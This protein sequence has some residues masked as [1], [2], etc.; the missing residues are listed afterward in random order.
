MKIEIARVF[1][2][3]LKPA[4]Y[5][6]VHGGRGS[7]KSHFFAEQVV[8]KTFTEP[9]NVV[10]L[11]EVQHT[12]DESVKKLIED[13]IL[14]FGWGDYYDIQHNRIITPGGGHIIFRGMQDANA[15]NIKSLEGFDI[16][17]F[18]EAQAMSQRSLELLRPTIRA[19]GSE[20]WFSW[21][22]EN[23]DDP[24]D[25]FLRADE[26]PEGA[27]V[28][29]ANW[30]DNPWFPSE[31]EKERQF[32]F[33]HFP[34]RYRHIWEGAYGA[35]GEP[36]FEVDWLLK[37]GQPLDRMLRPDSIFLTVDTAAKDGAEHDGTAC[38]LWAQYRH[39]VPNEPKLVIVD[40]DITQI[41]AVWLKEWLPKRLDEGKAFADS[42]GARYGFVGAWIEDKSSGIVL[43]QEAQTIGLP[44]EAIDT[45][46]TSVG[47]EGR[48][49]AIA[50]HVAAGDVKI[51]RHAFD[52]VIRYR[53]TTK[54]HLLAQIAAFRIGMPKKEHLLDLIDC[55][56][57]GVSI[58]IGDSDGW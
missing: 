36:F 49:L 48:A 3:L 15:H 35:K 33:K 20:L 43:I 41:K 31:L 28:I 18:E 14:K 46:L 52:K 40:Y 5:K 57:Y 10:C 54:N 37:D 53:D 4:R 44:V 30:R 8:L 2:P 1:R 50:R 32:D 19:T 17:W 24:I 13:K 58:G 6:G 38:I 56:T 26:I 29:E 45:K 27:I 55:F 21:N 11:R 12:L 25:A 23:E 9:H 34:N 42:V 39:L 22:P 47:K 16:A 51:N 7:G